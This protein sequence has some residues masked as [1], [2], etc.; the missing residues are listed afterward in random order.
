MRNHNFETPKKK[1]NKLLIKSQFWK[2]RNFCKFVNNV[3]SKNRNFYDF[4]GII[5]VDFEY[6]AVRSKRV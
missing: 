6:I 5:R 4:S 3:R 1:L 2:D